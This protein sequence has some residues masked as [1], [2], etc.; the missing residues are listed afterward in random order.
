MRGPNGINLP[1]DP[2]RR[3]VIIT[4]CSYWSRNA[5]LLHRSDPVVPYVQDSKM[6]STEP[7]TFLVLASG[8][9][10][11]S[12]LLWL[13]VDQG[14]RPS[15]LFVD[16]GQAAAQ[17]EC[18]AVA[19]VCEAL[20]A[21]WRI[22]RYSGSGFGG[23]EIRGRNAFLLH[24]ALMEFP[25]RSGVVAIGIH[26][27]TGYDD[28]SPEFMDAMQRSYQLHTGGAVTIATPFLHWTKNQIYGLATYLG[29]PLA[30]TYSCEAANSPCNRCRSCMDRHSL[31]V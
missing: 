25:G 13:C 4:P 22:V 23:G 2:P 19:R 17:S 10:D 29:V 5:R 11:S 9:V 3:Y 8:G 14:I 12:S 15:V 21:P 28:C 24:T 1:K 6:E 26:A 7:Q 18:A 31:Q 27:G 30:H 20:S 16:Y